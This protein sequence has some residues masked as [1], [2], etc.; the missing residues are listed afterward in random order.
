MLVG[1]NLLNTPE[2]LN[3][4]RRIVGAEV[5]PMPGMAF[6]TDLQTGTTEPGRA[7]VLNRDRITLNLYNSRSII[8]RDYPQESDF[9]RFAQVVGYAINQTGAAGRIPSAFGYNFDLV[10]EQDTGLPAFRYLA[11]H[12]FADH[13]LGSEGWHLV[14]GS[15]RVVFGDNEKTW[16]IAIEPRFNDPDTTRLFLSLNMHINKSQSPSE[17]E[18]TMAIEEA[19]TQAYSFMVRLDARGT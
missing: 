7:F 16:T 5:A 11:S 6:N 13:L 4:F 17:K 9:A 2:Q 14:G 10:Y 19:L 12:L 3:A 8:K 18:I 15:G 1:V